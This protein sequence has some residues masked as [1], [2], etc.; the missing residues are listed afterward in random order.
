[1]ATFLAVLAGLIGVFFSG[2]G[3][4]S[5]VAGIVFLIQKVF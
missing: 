4:F 1:M 2:L 5:L 3:F